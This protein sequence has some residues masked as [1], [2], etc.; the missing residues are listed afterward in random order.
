M[1]RL[2]PVARLEHFAITAR[3]Q[4]R[5]CSH[6]TLSLLGAG[7]GRSSS[8]SSVG[9]ASERS[10]P[11]SCDAA[12]GASAG[13][14]SNGGTATQPSQCQSSYAAHFSAQPN[15]EALARLSE[16]AACADIATEGTW[17]PQ[18]VR[19]RCNPHI[20]SPLAEPRPIIA[21]MQL[22]AYGAQLA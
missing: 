14:N 11:R 20:C 19:K 4:P 10:H 3:M 7:H 2:R 15:S 1:S 22:A 18:Q 12:Q 21:S 13:S 16:P 9:N 17:L 6:P 8:K 5:A